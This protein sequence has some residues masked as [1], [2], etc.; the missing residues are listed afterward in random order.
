M[1]GLLVP[2]STRP[3]LGGSILFLPSS[4]N[5][6]TG[7]LRHNF[8]EPMAFIEVKAHD[9][10]LIFAIK[11]LYNTFIYLYIYRYLHIYT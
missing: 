10:Y 5:C 7:P 11:T 1:R 2:A 6:E 4:R 9:S 8:D 3:V